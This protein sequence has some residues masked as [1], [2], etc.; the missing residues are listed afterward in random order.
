MPLQNRPLS[1]TAA[2]VYNSHYSHRNKKLH[3]AQKLNLLE[4]DEIKHTII[5][6]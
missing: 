6:T 1:I 5:I 4:V 2:V 3:F